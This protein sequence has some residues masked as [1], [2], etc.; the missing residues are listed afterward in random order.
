MGP[1]IT[2]P[3]SH[4]GVVFVFFSVLFSSQAQRVRGEG[5]DA[6]RPEAAMCA[7]LH[8]HGQS[9]EAG[10]R[11]AVVVHGVREEVSDAPHRALR[12]FSDESRGQRNSS[13]GARSFSQGHLQ[14]RRDDP[15]PVLLLPAPSS[16]VNDTFEPL[17]QLNVRCRPRVVGRPELLLC[18]RTFL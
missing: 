6:G 9:V 10:L 3:G 15:P 17:T 11:G 16:S 18:S 13:Q 8:T 7:G 2:N 4:V 14:M 12:V 5:D 1:L